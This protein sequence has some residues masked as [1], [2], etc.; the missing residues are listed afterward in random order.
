MKVNDQSV[1]GVVGGTGPAG[2]AISSRLASTGVRVLL[3]SRDAERA[4]A[5]AREL[6]SQWPGKLGTLEGA[7]NATAAGADVVIIATPWD[8]AVATAIE[9]RQELSGKTVISMANALVKVGREFHAIVPSRGS[10]ASQIQ[11][12]LPE[13]RVSAAF[14]HLP[15]RELAD[16][17]APVDSDVI[18]CSD[19]E[20]GF[21]EGARVAGKIEGVRVLNAGSLASAGPVESMTAVLL[22]MNLKHKAHCALRITGII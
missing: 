21:E 6:Q 17:S 8:A 13:S 18:V 2:K 12:A 10:V 9:L 16:L 1:I 14:Q 22:T 20:L 5:I 15:A 4:D 11:A 19:S 3:G 7:D